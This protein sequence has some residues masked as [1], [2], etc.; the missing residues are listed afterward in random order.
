MIQVQKYLIA[1]VL[2]GLLA[3][4]AQAAPLR[5][6]VLIAEEGAAYREF[7]LTFAAKATRQSLPLNIVQATSLPP[8]SD[9]IVAVGLKSAALALNSDAPVLCVL[10]SKAGFDKLLRE[11]PARRD[12]NT[13]SAIYLDQPSRRQTDLVAAA[14]PEAKKIGLLFATLPPDIASLRKAVAETRM[15]LVEQQL[16]S[17]ESLHRDLHALLQRSDVLL[18]TPDAQIYNAMTIRNILLE[19]YRS[20]IPVVGFSASYVKAGA[21]CAVF[22]TPEQIAGQAAYLTQQFAATAKLPAAQYPTEFEVLVNQQVSHSLEIKIK[23]N[24]E[25]VKQIKS[26][27]MAEGDN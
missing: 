18:A 20:R 16:G 19:T 11:L 9:L 15:V 24:A 7:A 10:V 1:F 6:T 13:V 25:L 22:S 27:A 26:A 3:C 23:E 12:Q 8:E 5:V 21:L 4:A 17:A 2:L 14:L